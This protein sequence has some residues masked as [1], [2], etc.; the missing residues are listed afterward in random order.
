MLSNQQNTINNKIKLS[1]QQQQIKSDWHPQIRSPNR[2]KTLAHFARTQSHLQCVNFFLSRL[3]VPTLGADGGQTSHVSLTF[4]QSSNTTTNTNNTGTTHHNR[5]PINFKQE[6][7]FNLSCVFSWRKQKLI[8]W[9]KSCWGKI[10]NMSVAEIRQWQKMATAPA[11][12]S[13]CWNP[14]PP[15]VPHLSVRPKASRMEYCINC[16][17]ASYKVP[18]PLCCRPRPCIRS[19]EPW[20]KAAFH[21]QSF[22]SSTPTSAD[23][24]AMDLVFLYFRICIST[25]LYLYV[26][27]IFYVGRRCKA[28][29]QVQCLPPTQTRFPLWHFGTSGFPRLGMDD[30]QNTE[31]PNLRQNKSVFPLNH[32]QSLSGQNWPPTH[33]THA[34]GMACMA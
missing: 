27:Y 16:T 14:N 17:P 6:Y 28:T 24:P 29:Y 23:C 4:C 32:V 18:T 13:F 15:P 1:W 7:K 5:H 3:Q 21:V 11:S 10:R 31:N 30:V 34:H 9:H 8:I 26:I 2:Q 22:P 12:E 20:A 25:S 33:V 19:A